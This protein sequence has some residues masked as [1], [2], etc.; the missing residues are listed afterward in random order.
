MD[1]K[2]LQ[3]TGQIYH[4]IYKIYKITFTNNI[5]DSDTISILAFFSAIL[6]PDHK[7]LVKFPA[8]EGLWACN[9]FPRAPAFSPKETPKELSGSLFY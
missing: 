9:L 6:V 4:R 1:V 7:K 2:I 8:S 3:I 5:I